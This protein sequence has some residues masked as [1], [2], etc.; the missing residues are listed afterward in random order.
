MHVSKNRCSPWMWRFGIKQTTIPQDWCA[1]IPK[2]MQ[3]L[4][5]NSSPRSN[6][7]SN[8]KGCE[9][10]VSIFHE[11]HPPNRNKAKPTIVD[12]WA[13]LS[14]FSLKYVTRWQR[15]EMQMTLFEL[16]TQNR[17][18]L[19]VNFDFDF[20]MVNWIWLTLSCTTK[21]LSSTTTQN[22]QMK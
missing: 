4:S 22:R 16:V 21:L 17:G 18:R 12:L 11:I 13:T 9:P 7:R 15:C 2:H 1:S 6:E 8:W 5:E 19:T 3:G 14:F 10:V 20:R